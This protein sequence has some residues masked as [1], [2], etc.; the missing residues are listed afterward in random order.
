MS[1][2]PWEQDGFKVEDLGSSYRGDLDPEK[3]VW[4]QIQRCNVLHSTGDEILYGN[5][6]MSLLINCPADIRED[7]ESR[8]EEYHIKEKMWRPQKGYSADPENPFIINNR[9]DLDYDPAFRGRRYEKDGDGWRE[10]WETGGPH[11]VSPV[12]RETESWDYYQLQKMIMAALQDHGLTWKQERVEMATGEEWNES[13][14]PP[15]PEEED[16]DEP[17]KP[18]AD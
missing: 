1:S 10:V 8:E 5:A 18:G 11:Q 9:G 14:N 2:H 12:Y 6:V 15:P 17:V 4:L 16:E 3:I 7:I 13:F